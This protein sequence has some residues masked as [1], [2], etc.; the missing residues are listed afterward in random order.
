VNDDKYSEKRMRNLV[1]YGAV[2][3]SVMVSPTQGG[4][5]EET[6]AYA[7]MLSEQMGGAPLALI[8]SLPAPEKRARESGTR[9]TRQKVVASTA[10]V[11]MVDV[12]ISATE[13]AGPTLHER[14]LNTVPP[15]AQ[16]FLVKGQGS[17]SNATFIATPGLAVD[18]GCTSMNVGVLKGF[19]K[20]VQAVNRLSIESGREPIAGFLLVT[21]TQL[22]RLKLE[23][24]G[25][26]PLV[27]A[28]NRAAL[29]PQVEQ[30]FEKATRGLP[31][32]GSQEGNSIVD[33]LVSVVRNNKAGAEVVQ[34]LLQGKPMAQ[35][36][37]EELPKVTGAH[38][39][40]L[41]RTICMLNER[42]EA[43]QLTS[44]KLSNVEM[45]PDQVKSE[46]EG[47]YPFLRKVS[48]S[49]L[50]GSL[51]GNSMDEVFLQQVFITPKDIELIQS[52]RNQ[53]AND[54]VL[55]KAAA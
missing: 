34:R 3:A 30:R 44:V 41:R 29:V 52:L 5:V 17:G 4:T 6:L 54:S 21:E 45:T 2:K 36:L 26:Q 31:Y 51:R 14:A 9:G 25:Y 48:V 42:F 18:A 28:V 15:S 20:G 24:L 50:L 10:G 37:L 22:K 46:F 38:A 12:A 19:L 11:K 7:T 32:L 33:A 43:M 8:S 53:Q 16:Y 13:S 35:L 27:L 39:Q 47:H 49:Q 55:L 23:E 1:S 40:V